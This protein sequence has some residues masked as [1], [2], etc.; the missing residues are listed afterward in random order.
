MCGDQSVVGVTCRVAA[1]C[2]RGLIAGLLQLEFC[3]AT[4]ISLN[5]HVPLFRLQ[6]SFDGHRLDGAQRLSSDCFVG[7][8]AAESKTPRLRILHIRAIASIHRV[9]QPSPRIR[10]R[11][12]S[13]AATAAQHSGQQCPAATSGLHTVHFTVGVEG[14][15]LLIAF[16]LGPVDVGVVMVLEHHLPAFDR[17]AVFIGLARPALDNG[18]ARLS[19]AVHV[20]A[21]IEGVLEHRDHV[22]VADRCP[23]K[24][25]QLLAVRGA[26]EMN[27][28][29]RERQQDLAGAAQLAKTSEDQSDGLLQAHVWVEAQADLA[30]PD[31]ADGNADAQFAALRL[32]AGRVEHARPEH[33]EFELADAALHTQQQPIV[34]ATRVVDAVKINDT[35]LDQAAQLQQMVPVA[36]IACQS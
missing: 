26:G 25:H 6:C 21:C 7:S 35:G 3:D 36:P 11:Q 5:F 13:P 31:V 23:V 24:A 20:H 2:E 29:R 30:M 9:A 22:A 12:A 1:L 10:H 8:P 32:G 18:G 14:D 17:L 4:L 33:A 15:L 27:L 16:E 19:L 34:G 28:V